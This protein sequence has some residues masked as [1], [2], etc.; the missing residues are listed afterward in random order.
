[1]VLPFAH[2]L[3]RNIFG[4]TAQKG[5]RLFDKMR[6]IGATTLSPQWQQAVFFF[7]AALEDL[8]TGADF[9]AAGSF[10]ASEVLGTG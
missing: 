1:M 7:G 8:A 5:A 9:L 6:Y 3:A 10:L 2:A 4:T